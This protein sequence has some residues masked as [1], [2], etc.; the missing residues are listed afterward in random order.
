MSSGCRFVG[1]HI[2]EECSHDIHHCENLKLHT[3]A[4]CLPCKY[5]FWVL[6]WMKQS[7]QITLKM[8]LYYLSY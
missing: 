5:L 4:S 2:P 6:P 8:A 3:A 7:K 1:H